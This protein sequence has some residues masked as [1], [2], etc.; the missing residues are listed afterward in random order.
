MDMSIATYQPATLRPELGSLL[1]VVA[2]MM[3]DQRAVVLHV[4]S[5]QHGEGTTTV[6]RELAAAAARAAWCRVA[7]LD[8]CSPEPGFPAPAPLLD[9]FERAELP[10]LRRG[11]INSAEV[12]IGC[13]S[14]PSRTAPRVENVRKLYG[15]L[16]SEYTLTVVDCPPVLEARDTAVLASVADGTLLVVEAERTKLSDIRRARDI[17]DQV[18]AIT[19]GAVLNK[20]Q[21]Q[22]PKL[23]QRM[24]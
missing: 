4:T 18:G 6:A 10:V 9:A 13:L 23:L 2:M 14:G 24:L 3:D 12:A 21:R 22:I 17:L 11:H 1:A 8:G 15:W 16:R 7:L 19:M 20:R 5:V